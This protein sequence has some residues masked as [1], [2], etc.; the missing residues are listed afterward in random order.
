MRNYVVPLTHSLG[1]VWWWWWW[2]S[3]T[4]ITI[5]ICLWA[6]FFAC[7]FISGI[8]S[9]SSPAQDKDGKRGEKVRGNPH[10]WFSLT[11]PWV[12][13]LRYNK[14]LPVGLVFYWV[15]KVERSDFSKRAFFRKL[16]WYLWVL[17]SLNWYT[18]TSYLKWG[19]GGDQHPESLLSSIK[20]GK[21]YAQFSPPLNDVHQ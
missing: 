5:W 11:T 18:V 10:P 12:R 9:L 21:W 2:V 20:S 8:V 1:S 19:G 6:S 7:F 13:E 15:W 4:E 3:V 14:I 17:C 16:V